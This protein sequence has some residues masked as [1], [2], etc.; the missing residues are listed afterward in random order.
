[1]AITTPISDSIEK[2]PAP[3]AVQ[4]VAPPVA[5]QA[6][7]TA[8]ILPVNA[9]TIP[10]DSM[11]GYQSIQANVQPGAANITSEALVE[12]RLAKLYSQQNESPLMRAARLKANQQANSIGAGNST[13][14]IQAGEQAAILAGLDIVKPDAATYAQAQLNAQQTQN[15][16]ALQEQQ[17]AQAYQDATQKSNLTAALNLQQGEIQSGLA[18]QQ[19][20]IQTNMEAFKSALSGASVQQQAQ[21]LNQQKEI[22]MRFNEAVQQ[23]NLNADTQKSVSS[24]Y[25]TASASLASNIQTIQTNPDLDA[26]AKKA[27]ID[28]MQSTFYK[29]MQTMANIAGI[30]L[31]FF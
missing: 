19:A 28:A 13:S 31:T 16:S 21:I 15:Q 9:G 3:P 22:E 27:A 24:M 8:G 18:Q 5:P 7:I 30:N 14:A 29:D 12:D 2:Q 20:T 4:P 10:A 1:M 17:A 23:M 11:Q 6:D 25:A 26:A